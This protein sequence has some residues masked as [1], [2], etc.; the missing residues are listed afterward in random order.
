MSRRAVLAVCAVLVLTISAY[1]DDP[2]PPAPQTPVATSEEPAPDANYNLCPYD[3]CDGSGG[4][5]Y[6]G[7]YDCTAGTGAGAECYTGG[8][9]W[10]DCEGGSICWY[11]PGGGVQCQPYCGRH[12]C[13]N[14]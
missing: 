3:E 14:T 9:Y 7:C 5:G 2:P 1:A 11:M 6:L 4:S 10:R 8:R 12:R 13:Y